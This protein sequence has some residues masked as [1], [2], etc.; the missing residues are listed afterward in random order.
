M[1]AFDPA[2][3]DEAALATY[4][5][6]LAALEESW[7]EWARTG[8]Q[9][10]SAFRSFLHHLAPLMRPH[11]WRL[12]EL[13]VYFAYGLFTTL[14]LPLG[15]KYLVDEI[16]PR[17]DE[18]LLLGFVL[19]LVVVFLLN[20]AILM[21]RAYVLAAVS[22]QITVS[23]QE[24]MFAHLQRLPHAF[25]V[26]SKVGDVLTRFGQDVTIVEGALMTFATG[27]VFALLSAVARRSPWWSS[28][29]FSARWSRWWCPCS[30]SSTSRS[31]PASAA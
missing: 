28:A 25:F 14:A 11:K 23:L 12:A 13:S 24:R 20:A 7:L 27:G 3:Q 31:P 17:R 21:R 16:L 6:P 22:E 5:R 10:G 18:G 4:H 9:H 19:G 2:R 29:R 15:F 1:G 30:P 8:G 26:R